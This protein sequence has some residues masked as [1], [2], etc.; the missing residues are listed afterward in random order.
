LTLIRTP[1][2]HD[3]QQQIVAALQTTI[4]DQKHV[5]AALQSAQAAR[6]QAVAALR[7]DYELQ[8]CELERLHEAANVAERAA[9]EAREASAAAEDQLAQMARTLNATE[10]DYQ[11]KWLKALTLA[12]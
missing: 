12:N 10:R 8:R 6:D 4:D 3:E 2:T 7:A 5:I 11:F 9:A 1:M